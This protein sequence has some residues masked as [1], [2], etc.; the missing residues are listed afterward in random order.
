MGL[1]E[2]RDVEHQTEQVGGGGRMHDLQTMWST[3]GFEKLLKVVMGSYMI[4]FILQDSLTI[5]PRMIW[6]E[7]WRPGG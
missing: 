4:T 3:W 1:G 7:A 6:V 5:V 2:E